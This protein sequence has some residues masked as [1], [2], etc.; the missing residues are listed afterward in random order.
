MI[1][2]EEADLEI[3]EK[4]LEKG[5]DVRLLMMKYNEELENVQREV[6]L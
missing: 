1:C 5:Q 4:L 3:Y 2:G 6:T